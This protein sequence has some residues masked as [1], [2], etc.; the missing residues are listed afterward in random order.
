MPALE[1]ES[2]LPIY[3][4]LNIHTLTRIKN[5]I[6]HLY[7]MGISISY[8]QVMELEDWIATSVCERFE[9]D[10]VVSPDFLRKGL[11]L[12]VTWII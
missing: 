5:L 8:D 12:S 3:I 11:F 7:H 1:R 6:Q 10:G 2:P 9:E 4:G